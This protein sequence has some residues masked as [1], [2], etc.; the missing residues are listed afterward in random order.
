[1]KNDTKFF[2]YNISYKSFDAKFLHSNFNKT[3]E[4]IRVYNE[5]RFLV[6]FGSEK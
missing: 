5:T 1:M 4:F 6:L 2:N 3:D